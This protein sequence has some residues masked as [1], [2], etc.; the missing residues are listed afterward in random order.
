M[1]YPYSEFKDVS[2]SQSQNYLTTNGQ[3]A[4]LAWYQATIWD[5]QQ[6]FLSLQRKLS[7]SMRRPV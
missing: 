3:S 6:I 7:F 1:K 5:P 2:S 4:R